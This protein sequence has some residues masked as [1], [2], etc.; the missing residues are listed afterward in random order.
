[1]FLAVLL[2]YAAITTLYSFKLKQQVIVDVML[3][4]MLYTMRII[5]GSAATHV[6]PSFW[7]LAFSMFVFFSLALVK[8]YSELAPLLVRDGGETIAGRGY[9]AADL[10]V[11]MALGVASG[12]N[13]VL[14]LAFYVDSPEVR[15]MYPSARAILFAPALIL[16]W[17]GRLW[18][19]ARRGEVHDD[20]VV[21]AAKDWQTLAIVAVLGLLFAIASTRLLAG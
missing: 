4:A 20:P 16:Y 6:M 7:L 17:I 19:K 2:V 1:M 8:R 21:F 10:P 9:V 12:M 18:M 3:L 13:A 14:V 5:G 11:L 15:A